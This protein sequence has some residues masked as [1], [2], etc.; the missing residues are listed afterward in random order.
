MAEADRPSFVAEIL[1]SPLVAAGVNSG[2][3]LWVNS[4]LCGPAVA[5]VGVDPVR[6]R[7]SAVAW[8]HAAAE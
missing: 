5:A 6:G 2:F 1:G 7:N 8:M 4:D 3:L